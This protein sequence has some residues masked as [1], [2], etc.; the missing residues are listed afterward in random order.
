MSRINR[1]RELGPL[2]FLGVLRYMLG[3]YASIRAIFTDCIL[4]VIAYAE[5]RTNMSI[6]YVGK[7]YRKV[8]L[9]WS[10]LRTKLFPKGF[11]WFHT[12]RYPISKE[13]RKDCR[14]LF[15]GTV[16]P[17]MHVRGGKLGFCS[18]HKPIVK[19]GWARYVE[20][21]RKN[22]AAWCAKLTYA[23]CVNWFILSTDSRGTFFY[24]D[25]RELPEWDS[26]PESAKRETG[27]TEK[28]MLPIAREKW[29]D[30]CNWQWI[31][32]EK[33]SEE[34]KW[35]AEH[36]STPIRK[37]DFAGDLKKVNKIIDLERR[38][39]MA[40]TLHPG[41]VANSAGERALAK[42]RADFFGETLILGGD[43]TLARFRARASTWDGRN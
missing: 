11:K 27:A 31:G 12:C 32:Y 40:R 23:C 8:R 7:K 17:N 16:T 1:K 35:I 14:R 18:K 24:F 41:S 20:A 25:T 15:W 39:E 33:E 34:L 29:A 4:P 2:V 13:P 6:I 36:L 3:M 9:W 28:C 19:A 5:K 43:K 10:G 26:L 30:L 42:M 38:N 21:R 37:P 22:T